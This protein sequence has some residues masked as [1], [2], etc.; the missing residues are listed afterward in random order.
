QD[1]IRDDRQKRIHRRCRRAKPLR[2]LCEVCDPSTR[3]RKKTTIAIKIQNSTKRGQRS[4]EI[5]AGFPSPSLLSPLMPSENARMGDLVFA[6]LRIR[7]SKIRSKWRRLRALS[8]DFRFET[9]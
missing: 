5:F 7:C 1:D 3:M 6:K 2:S 8:L 4:R 9:R